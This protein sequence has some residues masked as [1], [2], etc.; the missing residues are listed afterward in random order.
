MN[1][2]KGPANAAAC[3][4]PRSE[5]CHGIARPLLAPGAS[6]PALRRKEEDPLQGRA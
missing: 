2:F 4:L 1:L 5:P 6:K 3:L